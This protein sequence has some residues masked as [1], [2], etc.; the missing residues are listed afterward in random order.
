[1][2]FRHTNAIRW[3]IRA[4]WTNGNCNQ[5]KI[6]SYSKEVLS[7]WHQRCNQV[8]RVGNALLS[9]SRHLPAATTHANKEMV[10]MTAN[11]RMSL[12]VI[13]TWTGS[14][15]EIR[16]AVTAWTTLHKKWRRKKYNGYAENNFLTQLFY[17]DTI[18]F[19]TRNMIGVRNAWMW[20]S[21]AAVNGER[22][23]R[24]SVEQKTAVPF[25]WT[26]AW[27]A[28]LICVPSLLCVLNQAIVWQPPT[29]CT[30]VLWEPRLR[31]STHNQRIYRFKLRKLL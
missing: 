10:V 8:R 31:V 5:Q 11:R 25:R 16:I 7:T 13:L 17:N 4:L 18:S 6:H 22:S 12:L 14:C 3:R 27:Q 20:E 21:P 23:Q 30:M 9:K 1:M 28:V 26:Y 15:H 19:A 24:M 29:L 2:I